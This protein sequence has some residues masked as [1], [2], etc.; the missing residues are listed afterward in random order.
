MTRP[1]DLRGKVLLGP[2]P[3]MPPYNSNT[4]TDNLRY[5]VCDPESLDSSLSYAAQF[6]YYMTGQSNWDVTFLR[7]IVGVPSEARLMQPV[8]TGDFSGCYVFIVPTADSVKVYH[9]GTGANMEEANAQ[10]KADFRDIVADKDASRIRGFDPQAALATA[11][12]APPVLPDGYTV[13]SEKDYAVVMPGG[14][15]SYC[16]K[17]ISVNDD[18]GTVGFYCSDVVPAPVK[19]WAEI[20]GV[21]ELWR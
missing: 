1:M 16:L 13:G 11:S 14:G 6:Y 17:L 15:G 3:Y 12:T 7:W 20:D 8:F 19:G 2:N 9:V 18:N 10:V 4:H 21:E 5:V